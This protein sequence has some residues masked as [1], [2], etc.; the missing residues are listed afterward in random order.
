MAAQ[1]WLPQ[2]IE[3]GALPKR[4]QRLVHP[5]LARQDAAQLAAEAGVSTLGPHRR[6][7]RLLTTLDL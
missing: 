1:A 2:P 6:A 4:R 3:G 7:H 5:V